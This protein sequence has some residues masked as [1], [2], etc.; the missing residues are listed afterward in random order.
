MSKKLSIIVPVYNEGENIFSRLTDIVAF[1]SGII[2][3]E[4]FVVDDGSKDNTAE[5]VDR[6]CCL[7]KDC[8]LFYFPMDKNRGK[9]HCLR[10]ASW[11]VTGDYIAWLDG[12]NDIPPYH[13]GY[14][15]DLVN[16]DVVIGSKLHDKSSIKRSLL[17]S[18]FSHGY[19]MLI[20]VLFNL[21]YK[22]TQTGI[23]LFRRKMLESILSKLTLKR[24]AFDLE[25]MVNLYLKKASVLEIPVDIKQKRSGFKFWSVVKMFIDT[26]GVWWRLNV[27]KWYQS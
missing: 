22:D 19:A 17:R 26:L 9:G 3:F 15:Y 14:L 20:K 13:L 8:N 4:I 7:F 1:V 6:F 27:L 24:F 5:E 12:D 21:P 2:D 11:W 18:V 10:A 16:Y 25:V 23:K